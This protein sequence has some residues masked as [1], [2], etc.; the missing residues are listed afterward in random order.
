[1]IPL[2]VD[3]PYEQGHL[4]SLYHQYGIVDTIEHFEK[5]ARISGRIPQAVLSTF[6]GY[7][8]ELESLSDLT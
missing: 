8:T 6:D 5:H 7:D 2:V 4:I 3:I 1:M